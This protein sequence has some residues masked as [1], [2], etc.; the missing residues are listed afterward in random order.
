[1]GSVVY[2][3]EGIGVDVISRPSAVTTAAS[4]T[5]SNFD[6]GTDVIRS[7]RDAYILLIRVSSRC[8]LLVVLSQAQK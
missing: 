8:L 4:A 6:S 5:S 3:S 1:M 2:R 7:S